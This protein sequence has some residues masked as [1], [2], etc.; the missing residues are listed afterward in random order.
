VSLYVP[1]N[2]CFEKLHRFDSWWQ[3]IWKAKADFIK[4]GYT[5]L[6]PERETFQKI[7]QV[8]LISKQKFYLIMGINYTPIGIYL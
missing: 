6:T 5:K 4:K 1:F 3:S 2:N 7:R 8:S